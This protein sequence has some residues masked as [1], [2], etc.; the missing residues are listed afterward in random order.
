MWTHCGPFHYQHQFTFVSSGINIFLDGY[1]PTENLRFRETSLVFKVAETANEEEVKRLRHY[2]VSRWSR[3]LFIII[4]VVFFYWLY[5]KINSFLL[6]VCSFSIQ[7][8]RRRWASSRWRSEQESSRTLRSWWCSERTVRFHPVNPPS[9]SFYGGIMKAVLFI[10]LCLMCV[11]L[12]VCLQAQG[13]RL[14]SGCWPEDS[15][16]TVE[17]SHTHVHH[18]T[19]RLPWQMYRF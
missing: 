12:F 15:N 1:V 6:L 3:T 7:K 16:L 9:S 14:S 18:N 4:V 2:Q 11:L 10:Y 8:W 13:R 17:V 19:T 5:V